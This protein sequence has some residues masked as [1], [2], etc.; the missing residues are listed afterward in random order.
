M[1]FE[2]DFTVP[3][4]TYGEYIDDNVVYNQIESLIASSD[5]PLYLHATTMQNHQPYSDGD[6][7]DEFINYLS[8]IQH[9]A[10]GLADFLERLSKM[11]EP[12]IV[13]FVGDHFPSLRGMTAS[14]I[15]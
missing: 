5:E 6:S 7:S 11:D 14:T 15:S 13:L 12:T 3:V 1:I 4:S 8:R 10:D 9:S 2:N